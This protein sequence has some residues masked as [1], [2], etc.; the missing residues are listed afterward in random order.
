MNTE[1][2]E[3]QISKNTVGHN[4][5]DIWIE[6]NDGINYVFEGAFEEYQ[7]RAFAEFER[8]YEFAYELLG[9]VK[10]WSEEDNGCKTAIY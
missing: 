4:D 6:A 1:Y 3:S 8:V 9:R 5:M 10:S 7:L 2:I